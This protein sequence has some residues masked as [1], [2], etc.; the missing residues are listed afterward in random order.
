[1]NKTGREM[2]KLDNSIGSGHKAHDFFSPQDRLRMQAALELEA[3]N[4]KFINGEAQAHPSRPMEY[5][6]YRSDGTSFPVIIYGAPIFENGTVTGSRGIIVD[7]SEQKAIENKLRESEEKYRLLFEAESDAIFMIDAESGQ[8]LDV[9]PAATRS[10]GY[11]RQE[12]LAMKNTDVSAEPEKTIEATNQ[13]QTKVLIRYHKKKDGTILPVELS[14]GFT[15]FR[16][17]KIQIVTARD[18]T[19]NKKMQDALRESENKYKL[20]VES[21]QDGILMLKADLIKYANQAI[22]QMLGYSLDEILDRSVFEYLEPSYA[23]AGKAV[24]ERRLAGDDSTIN[25]DFHF[26]NKHGNMIEAETISSII[27]F[28]G[29]RVAF[30]TIHNITE[31]N[32][33]QA[34]LRESE[35][36]YRELADFMPQTLFE[37]D[38]EFR[39]QYMNKTGMTQFGVTEEEF[40]LFS[41]Q[42]F[43]AD[44]LG[45]LQQNLSLLLSGSRSQVICEYRAISKAG[46]VVPILTYSIPIKKEGEIVGVRG[47]IIDITERIAIENEL[48]A[49]KHELEI[50]NKNL[51]VR[52]QESSRRLA[53]THTQLIN[54]QKENIQSQF[55][56]LRQQVNPHFL[57]NSLNVLTSLI[58]IEP[59]LAE[60][61]SEHLSKVYRYVLENKDDE[62]VTL[63]TELRFLDAYI[64]LLNIRFVDKIKFNINLPDSTLSLKIIP[65]AMQLLIENAIKHNI[66]TKSAPLYIDI[67]I[68][69]TG[70]LNIINNL[71]ERPSQ[72]VSTGVGLKNIENRYLLLNNTRPI[73]Q[74]T[75]THFVAKVPLVE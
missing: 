11:S 18:I 57:F 46:V 55:D 17:Q 16:G 25:M 38:R 43:A 45:K 24:L 9:N 3:R 56:V 41:P 50:L 54:L 32:R 49:A 15:I 29:E 61:F 47:I 23:Q 48:K 14:A 7:I 35:E 71:Q 75:E 36:K 58:K 51:E 2:F 8:I 37:L 67:F 22:C 10:Y 40:G 66:M 62:L 65:L 5:T 70:F 13:R 72:I 63:S 20:L 21:S 68:D 69:N 4:I 28:N 74:K 12:L 53:E 44:D 33:M 30:Y 34:E 52:V 6:A 59:D 26:R 39:L 31:R 64:F 1:M 27:D 42:Y 73:F 60:Q 19:E